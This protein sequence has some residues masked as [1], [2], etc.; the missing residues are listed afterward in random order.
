MRGM[1]DLCSKQPSTVHSGLSHPRAAPSLT[2]RGG[3]AAARAKLHTIR[4]LFYSSKVQTPHLYI[5]GKEIDPLA[6]Y[7]HGLS[8]S[9]ICCI[10]IQIQG[11][12]PETKA[13]LA[14]DVRRPKQ[15]IMNTLRVLRSPADS[16]IVLR[17]SQLRWR[18]SGPPSSRACRL[19]PPFSSYEWGCLRRHAQAPNFG[20]RDVCLGYASG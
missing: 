5:R 3:R 9:K 17:M 8:Y 10:P 16:M 11:H 20:N 4:G 14:S 7:D 13:T 19:D 6:S 15:V 12:R 1:L 2:F 18:L